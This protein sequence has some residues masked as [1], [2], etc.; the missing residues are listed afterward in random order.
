SLT[1]TA[2]QVLV[3][4]GTLSQ[5]GAITLTLP[6]NIATTSTPTFAS[7]TLSGNTNQLTLGTGNTATITTGTLTSGHTYTL[8]DGDG[9]FCLV[10]LNNCA[11]SGGGGIGGSGSSH[12]IPIFT[13]ATSLGNSDIY[14]N[15]KIGIGT[16][17]PEG[18]FSVSGTSPGFALTELNQTGTGDILTGSASGATKFVFDATGDLNIVGVYQINGTNVVTSTSLGSSVVSSSLTSVGALNAGSITNGFGNIDTGGNITTEGATGY[19][20]SGTN[21]GLTFSGSGNHIIS[22]SSGTLELG[23][24][25]LTGALNANSNTITNVSTINGLTLTSNADGFSVAEETTS[26]TLTV[27]SNNVS[28]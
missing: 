21:A 14:D 1:G 27:S 6:Q 4:G 15:G 20:A 26:R 13:A 2:S 7:M 23:V 24:T 17:S 9:T 8:P 3:N 18:L 28:L 11:G 19:S 5:T 12:F 25:T 16:T 10:E 22:A